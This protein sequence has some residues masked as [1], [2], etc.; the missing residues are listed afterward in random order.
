MN[1]SRSPSIETYVHIAHGRSIWTYM[2][3]DGFTV[4]HH[5]NNAWALKPALT[6]AL[7]EVDQRLRHRDINDYV[8]RQKLTVLN[9]TWRSSATR[10]GGHSD[11]AKEKRR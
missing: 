2:C 7:L 11:P 5:E 4:M 8:L 9:L 6:E 1:A 3:A 10:K